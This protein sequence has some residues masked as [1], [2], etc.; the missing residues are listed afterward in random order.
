MTK[1]FSIVKKKKIIWTEE[2]D[3]LLLSLVNNGFRGKWR[4][5]SNYFPSKSNLDCYLRF[6]KIN[7]KFKKGKW[8]LEEDEL[9]K[10][11][12]EEHGY[13][14]AKI[15][16]LVKNRSSKQIRSRYIYYLENSLNKGKFSKEEDKLIRK[17]FPLLKNN[18]A[19]YI[20]YLPNRSAKIVQNRYRFLKT[21]FNNGGN[22]LNFNNN[23][24][25]SDNNNINSTN[26]LTN[27]EF[28]FKD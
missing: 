25:I 16:F 4:Y 2:D 14:W 27:K 20:N 3:K 5:I 24:N 9:I 26:D 7:P 10:K 6:G 22:N 1:I 28:T 13:D 11:L 17:L 21:V 23:N 15:S 19:Q 8:D 18:W 12:V